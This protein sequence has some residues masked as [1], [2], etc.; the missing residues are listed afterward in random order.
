MTYNQ[1]IQPE[2]VD[3]GGREIAMSKVTAFQAKAVY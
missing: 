3:I 2:I 1:F